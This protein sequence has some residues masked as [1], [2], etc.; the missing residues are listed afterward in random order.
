MTKKTII[1]GNSIVK[2]RTVTKRRKKKGCFWDK[3]FE[4]VRNKQVQGM[5][6]HD[7]DNKER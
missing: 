3:F 6:L 7:K 4:D 2:Y 1:L 5:R